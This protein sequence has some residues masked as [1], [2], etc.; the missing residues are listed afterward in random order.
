[1]KS[2]LSV[3][4]LG[5]ITVAGQAT[6]APAVQTAPDGRPNIVMIVTDDHGYGDMSVHGHPVLRTPN[7]DQL[8]A[9]SLRFTDFHVTPMC[10]Y[11][12]AQLMTSVHNLSSLTYLPGENYPLRPNLPTLPEVLGNAGYRTA[13]FGK[14]H[15]G[16]KAPL[17][18]H[19]RGFQDAVWFQG[20]QLPAEQYFDSPL[21]HR[22]KLQPHQGY[23]TDILFDEALAWI[24][25]RAAAREGERFFAYVATNVGHTPLIAP[26]RYQAPFLAQGFSKN[27]A[28]FLGMIKNLD[29]NIGR[30]EAL[31]ERAGLRSN[32][33]FVFLTD[34]GGHSARAVYPR[35]N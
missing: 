30:L 28:N 16:K 9:E 15:L 21:Y 2:A 19:D 22:E 4:F 25:A 29:D 5:L 7:L 10:I 34:N 6:A 11:T 20:A 3:I 24:E 13:L 31:L 27:D 12:R 1:M 35:F 32:T 8:H 14:W 33:L 26:E 23:C 17:R 18:P